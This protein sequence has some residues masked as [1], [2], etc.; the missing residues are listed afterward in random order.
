MDLTRR[1]EGPRCD[2]R[3][4]QD[5]RVQKPE[6]L[7]GVRYVLSE[8]GR[9]PLTVF[10]T[11][12]KRDDPTSEFVAVTAVTDDDRSQHEVPAGWLSFGEASGGL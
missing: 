11:D 6:L 1:P 5:G 8:P 4:A 12:L 2:P 7:G 9:A 3:W 10:V